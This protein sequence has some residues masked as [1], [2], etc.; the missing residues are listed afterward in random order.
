MVS[1]IV[2]SPAAW[3]WAA[4]LAS[5]SGSGAASSRRAR[6]ARRAWAIPSLV[7]VPARSMHSI[8]FFSSGLS[9]GSDSAASR[10]SAAWRLTDTAASEWA[11]TSWM[12]RAILARSASAAAWVS[13]YRAR[14]VSARVRSACSAR[15]RYS[16]LVMATLHI[17]A[18]A[19]GKPRTTPVGWLVSSA[20][21]TNAATVSAMMASEALVF[22]RTPALKAAAQPTA[23]AG[24]LGDTPA[25]TPP[26]PPITARLPRLSARRCP[27]GPD[28]SQ[29][30]QPA[31]DRPSVIAIV[32]P[33]GP[34]V[35]GP[36]SDSETLMMTATRPKAR[37]AS[38]ILATLTT[39][40]PVTGSCR[41]A[42]PNTPASPFSMPVINVTR[43]S[44]AGPGR[45]GGRGP[46]GDG[47]LV[48]QPVVKPRADAVPTASFLAWQTSAQHL[49]KEFEM[50]ASV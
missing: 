42:N 14:R 50:D 43:W 36:G 34:G 49:T 38:T 48:L 25:S 18:Y 1:W 41:V 9:T 2:A 19:N 27:V 35:P 23:M 32:T 17:P 10:P 7:S 28:S 15:T 12:S 33:R 16:R 39:R 46:G 3:Y 24:L 21:I 40:S 11:S 20:V 29:P 31:A 6:M 8:A 37:T 47:A 13:A 5:W 45:A 26:A 22:R 44:A 4:S 30:T